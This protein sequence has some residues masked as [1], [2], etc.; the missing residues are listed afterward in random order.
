MP[1]YVEE[2]DPDANSSVTIKE[3]APN[4]NWLKNGQDHMS[5][6]DVPEV[7]ALVGVLFNTFMRL[8]GEL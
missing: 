5:S 7:A 3:Q 4:P 2:D 6:T 1:R 8:A